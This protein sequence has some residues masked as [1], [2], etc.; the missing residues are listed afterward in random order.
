MLE[1]ST[2]S[3]EKPTF[4]KYKFVVLFV[5]R[6]TELVPVCVSAP[7]AELISVPDQFG[8]L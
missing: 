4:V 5:L 2:I 3:C 1:R 8:N 6:S 7:I